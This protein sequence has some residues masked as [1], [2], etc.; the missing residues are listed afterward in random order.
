MLLLVSNT[1][2]SALLSCVCSWVMERPIALITW[3]K[4]NMQHYTHQHYGTSRGS[5]NAKGT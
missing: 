4:E 1:T 5:I 3:T 2:A